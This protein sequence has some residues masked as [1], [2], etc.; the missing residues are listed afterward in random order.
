MFYKKMKDQTQDLHLKEVYDKRQIALKWISC[1]LRADTKTELVFIDSPYG[2][3]LKYNNEPAN[4]GNISSENELFYDEL[5]QVMD[6]SF[7][8]LDFGGVI[9]W[10]TL[11]GV[12]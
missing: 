7:R 2:D 6:E 11:I 1:H 8:I 3:N 5:K 9:G 10:L 4:I 12:R